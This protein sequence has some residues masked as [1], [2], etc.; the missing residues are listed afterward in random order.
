MIDK[1]FLINSENTG[2]YIVISEKTKRKYYVETIGSNTSADWGSYNPSTGNIEH[3]KGDGKHRGSIDRCESM[4]TEKDFD[5]I[6]YLPSGVSPLAFIEEL[7]K[8]YI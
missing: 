6:H 3:K 8:K 7:D 4:I 1:N 2:R 5:N